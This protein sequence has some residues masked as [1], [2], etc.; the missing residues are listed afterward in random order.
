MS[1]TDMEATYHEISFEQTQPHFNFKL[2][3]V[4]VRLILLFFAKGMVVHRESMKINSSC[5]ILWTSVGAAETV[6]ERLL[7][8]LCSSKITRQVTE[9]KRHAGKSV[10]A[11][12]SNLVAKP[13]RW[14]S[15]WRRT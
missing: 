13:S 9:R 15:K 1:I 12:T 14:R 11:M 4:L 5:S 2:E 10:G 7:L 3:C 8:Y 6:V